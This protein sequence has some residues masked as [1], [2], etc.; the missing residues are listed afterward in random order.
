MDTRPLYERYRPHELADVIG[1]PAAVDA[2]AGLEARSGFGGRAYWITGVSGAGKTTLAR[3]I[4]AGVADPYWV[5]EYDSADL[6]TAAVL[7]Q[8]SDDLHL[9]GG[10]SRGGRAWIVNEAH[11]LREPIIRRF[12]GI[13]ERLPSHVVI[14]FTTTRAGEKKLFADGIEGGP[15]LSRCLAIPLTNQG[16]APTFAKRAR[17][18]AEREN[19]NGR[20]EADYVK[21]LQLHHNNMRAAL[22]AIESGEMLAK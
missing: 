17:E 19:L 2:L 4:A 21:L 5:T 1:Q 15:L 6:V 22:Q 8:L 3:I 20:P 9:Y 10:G 18:I 16:L 11:G 12:E 13:L 7:R 14:I